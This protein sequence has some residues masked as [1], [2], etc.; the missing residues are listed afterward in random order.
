MRENKGKNLIALPSEYIVIDIETTGFDYRFY[1]IIEVAALKISNGICVDSYSSL[2]QPPLK[3]VWKFSEDDSVNVEEYY[4]DSFISQLTGITNEMLAAAPSVD[5]ILPVFLDFIGDS[6]LIGHNANFDINFIYDTAMDVL[7][8]PL[9]ND[10]IDTMRIARKVFPTLQHHRLSDVAQACDIEVSCAHRAANDCKTTAACYEFMRNYILCN[11]SEAEFI[12]SFTYNYE[13]QLAS[14]VA[15][16]GSIDSTNPLFGKTVVFTGA[17]SSMSR[18]DAFQIVAN[19]GGIPDNSV[20][21]K[22]NYLIIGNEEFTHSIK[23]GK[24]NKM[25]KA[26]EYL[27]KGAEISVMSETT[28]FDL[29]SDYK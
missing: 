29:I 4:V 16:V 2:I 10:F 26:E 5:D 24:T 11:S 3:E 15:S 20:T 9:E 23:E 6:V 13:K 18:K 28:F 7:G 12:K 25:R 19:L 27:A 17:L 8:T 21:K 1:D 14:V 22:T